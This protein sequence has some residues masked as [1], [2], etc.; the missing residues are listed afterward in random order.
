M[1]ALRQAITVLSLLCVLFPLHAQTPAALPRVAILHIGTPE[2]DKERR[3][4]FLQ[5]LREQGY[6]DGKNLLL[7][8]TFVAGRDA[9]LPEIIVEILGRKPAVLVVGGSQS[10]RAAK[11]ATATVPIVV[12]SVADPVGQGIVP[13]LSRP[14]GNITGIAILSEILIAKR[15]EILL[16]VVPNARR[17][18]YLANPKNPVMTALANVASTAAKRLGATVTVVKA[19]NEAEIEEALKG[20]TRRRFDAVLMSGDVTAFTNRKMIAELLALNRVPAMHG[21]AE[22]VDAGGL[23]SY[24]AGRGSSRHS[25]TFVS[26]ILKGAKP[27]DLPFEQ[28]TQMELVLNVKAA[29]NLGITFPLTVLLRA[30]RVIE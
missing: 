17:I 9:R 20:I 30:D 8:E 2:T 5:G 10:V 19:S 27:G 4:D 21:F 12:Y 29:K 25:A 18:A 6:V 1:K 13:S 22:N 15:V 16:E 3:L 11:T 23:M 7:D 24:S 26:R 14:G 28:P